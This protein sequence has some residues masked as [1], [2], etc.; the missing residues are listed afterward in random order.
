MFEGTLFS[1]RNVTDLAYV[2]YDITTISKPIRFRSALT[3]ARRVTILEGERV[4]I[5]AAANKRERE[6]F[7]LLVQ[8]KTTKEIASELFISEKTVRNHISNAMQKIG[9]ERPFASCC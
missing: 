4:S 6:V 8:D 7:E 2:S 3:L 5:K 1:V 9:S